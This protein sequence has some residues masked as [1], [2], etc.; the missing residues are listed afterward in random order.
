MDKAIPNR[1]HSMASGSSEDRAES[2]ESGSGTTAAG[3]A[4]GM[5]AEACLKCAAYGY[6][7]S[8]GCRE[9]QEYGEEA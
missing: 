2:R 7:C 6:F 4:R 3:H 9:W 1:R 8:P 5:E